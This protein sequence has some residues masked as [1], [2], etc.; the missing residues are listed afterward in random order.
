MEQKYL[1]W[2]QQVLKESHLTC[3]FDGSQK[4]RATQPTQQVLSKLRL[5]SLQLALRKKEQS[6]LL[7]LCRLWCSPCCPSVEQCYKVHCLYS[8]WFS[9]VFFLNVMSDQPQGVTA[10]YTNWDLAIFRRCGVTLCFPLE[11]NLQCFICFLLIYIPKVLSG[12][13]GA[14]PAALPRTPV[15]QAPLKFQ[16]Q[17]HCCAKCTK[18]MCLKYVIWCR[19]RQRKRKTNQKVT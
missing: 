14:P 6:L 10:P 9:W 13:W 4:K 8:P 3:Y 11:Q 19:K 7:S 17:L 12:P 15:G 16:E 5:L 2:D 18:T 1:C